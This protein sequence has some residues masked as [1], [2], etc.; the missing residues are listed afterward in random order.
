MAISLE[1]KTDTTLS[2]SPWANPVVDNEHIADKSGKYD[3]AL[4][5]N[6]PGVIP[7]ASA[8]STGKEASLQEHA[9]NVQLLELN[10]TRDSIIQ[11]VINENAGNVTP[12]LL[13]AINSL[14]S[15]D[16]ASGD[17]SAVLE[18]RYSRS[19]MNIQANEN[20]DAY[21][22]AIMTDPAALSATMDFGE[23]LAT[24]SQISYNLLKEVEAQYAQVNPIVKGVAWATD[25]IPLKQTIDTALNLNTP[26]VG[27]ILPGERMNETL[28]VLLPMDSGR[29]KTELT[30]LVKQMTDHGHYTMAMDLLNA[31]L[32]YGDDERVWG[33]FWTALDVASLVPITKIGKALKNVPKAAIKSFQKP[34]AIAV[35]LGNVAKGAEIAVEE[36]KKAG[37]LPSMHITKPD[38]VEAI[39]PSIA[40]PAQA[41]KGTT[42]VP[43]PVLERYQT[44]QL[45]RANAVAEIL[46]TN[47]VDRL[48]ENEIDSIVLQTSYDFDTK[49]PSLNANLHDVVPN[50]PDNITNIYT[51][52]ARYGQ[53]NGNA[54]TSED[55]ARMWAAKYVKLKSNDYKIIEDN[56]GYYVTIT[57]AIDESRAGPRNFNVEQGQADGITTTLLDKVTSPD[58][59]VNKRQREA[60]S[61]VT[62]GTEKMSVL[63]E[64]FVKPIATL[65]GKKVEFEEWKNFVKI[66]QSRV[67]PVK[68]QGLHYETADEFIDAWQQQYNKVPTFEQIDAWDA[69][70]H[71]YDTKAF[72]EAATVTKQ[73][74]VMGIEKFNVRRSLGKNN[75]DTLDFEGKEVDSIPWDKFPSVGAIENKTGMLLRNQKG[76]VRQSKET[77]D[78]MLE[79]GYKI[80]QPFNGWLE[81]AE[82]EGVNFLIVKD[83]KRGMVTID[84]PKK[85]VG[86][87]VDKYRN[88][89]KVPVMRNGRHSGDFT[90]FAARSGDEAAFIA[91]KFNKIKDTLKVQPGF[92]K[93]SHKAFKAAKKTFEDN[94][95]MWDFNTYAKLVKDGK[96]DL[97]Q[98]VQV[99]RAG[100]RAISPDGA[101]DPSDFNLSRQ[102]TGKVF[103]GDE[104]YY[105]TLA[106]EKDSVFKLADDHLDPL[107]G[108]RLSMGDLIEVNMLNDYKMMS[109]RDFTTQFKDILDF[110][111]FNNDFSV[112]YNPV[113]KNGVDKL[114]IQKAESIR[115]AIMTM[116]KQQTWTDRQ[117][118]AWR[119]KVASTIRTRIP[120]LA[121]KAE[122]ISNIIPAVANADTMLRRFAFE[123]KFW[124]NPKHLF[125]Q[126]TSAVNVMAI[127]PK[128]GAKA[129]MLNMPMLAMS[130]ASKN[131]SKGVLNR[132][133][134]MA[135]VKPE[136]LEEL[137]RIYAK[138][139]YDHVGSTIAYIDDLKPPNIV[140]GKFG[141][142][143]DFGHVF[144]NQG[145]R[146]SRRMAF[147]AAYLERKAIKGTLNRA[148]ENAILNRA[149]DFT[150]NMTRESS[151]S[152]QRGW[153]S[154]ATQFMGYHM[155]MMEQMITG[156]RGG[157]NAKLT[158]GEAGRLFGVMS[159][160]YGMPVAAGMTTGL[161][162]WREMIKGWMNENDVEY[163]DTLMEPFVDGLGSYILEYISGKDFDVAGPYGP[164]GLPT[165]YD[166]LKGNAEVT[167]ILLGAS[168]GI[169]YDTIKD[170]DPLIK[171]LLPFLDANDTVHWPPTAQDLLKPLQNITTVNNLVRLWRAQ[172]TG[173]WVS[174]NMNNQ[175]AI[176][177]G[178]AI[179]AVVSGILPERIQD[180]FTDLD[181]VNAWNE[182]SKQAKNEYVYNL[183]L[184]N[185]ALRAGDT[186][187]ANTYRARATA[188]KIANNWKTREITDLNQRVID[189]VPFDE[190]IMDTLSKIKDRRSGI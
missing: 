53:K 55:A 87:P 104:F 190:A 11:S 37:K 88:Y 47:K 106:T 24:K 46:R 137:T 169:I 177:I 23:E 61:A 86:R 119:E 125:L 89:G 72:L 10:R 5:E 17:I 111:N 153:T 76:F 80:I 128:F 42:K 54:W 97:D 172:N 164:G 29:Y 50:A 44:S 77:I 93:D 84:L 13:G 66:N 115:N 141:Q 81:V 14:G 107:E 149:K 143:L 58:L 102:I 109:V 95:P 156:F 26:G 99:T 131:A 168:G 120:V 83:F 31:T 113:Y 152:Y 130:Y 139:G 176:E 124:M 126:A 90:L 64:Q 75:Y 94:F 171:N 70:R 82:K 40:R 175:T 178:E 117:A 18:E 123:T 71:Y 151:A 147:A 133:A 96:I 186:A 150:G 36:A 187:L 180:A 7:I 15:A 63:M 43:A 167:D 51:V 185:D 179:T 60:R 127:S 22:E 144:F 30:R 112:L 21:D 174:K 3:A 59:K 35:T 157:A 158:R 132:M 68:G 98:P 73:K 135:G 163:D 170:A 41:A 146:Y 108:L 184:A 138:S 49:F 189:E 56:G 79:D 25:L 4:G 85:N 45:A 159:M 105:D 1:K 116:L 136:E 161:I 32:R 65:K 67:D 181:T 78:K 62:I 34:E 165:F 8:L 38:D 92:T 12:E 121:D 155:R 162:P 69:W 16:F 134:K 188:I 6:S 173:M 140:K 148:D 160:L 110:N 145:E 100:Q 166:W 57:S 91:D 103:D 39:L 52:T 27:N 129:A 19:L 28:N 74:A 122:D 101:K 182:A 2:L 118:Q 183:K 9:R 154:I 48:T 114:Q 142:I 33:N 20:T